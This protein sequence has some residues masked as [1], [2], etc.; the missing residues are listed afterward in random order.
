MASYS[1][2]L[3]QKWKQREMANR[4]YADTFLEAEL[5][6]LHALIDVRS[7]LALAIRASSQKSMKTQN[8]N[9]LP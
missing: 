8:G 9:L 3:K 7:Y 1:E 2:K 6:L 5:A 4:Q